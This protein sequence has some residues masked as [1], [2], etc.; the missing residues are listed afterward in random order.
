M[1]G[2]VSEGDQGESRGEEKPRRRRTET[3]GVADEGESQR[4]RS[5]H[6]GCLF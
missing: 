2:R 6:E 3:A 1:E 5:G 4:R